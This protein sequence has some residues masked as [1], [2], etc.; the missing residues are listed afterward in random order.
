MAEISEILQQLV[1]Q[2]D[3]STEQSYQF[4]HSVMHGQVSEPVLAS[5]L[6][7]LK[8]KTESRQEILGAVQAM[9]EA[10]VQGKINKDFVFMDTCGTG[11]DGKNSVNISTLCSLTLASLGIKIA[12]HGN[13]SVSS[14]SGSSDL[15]TELGYPIDLPPE[16]AEKQLLDQGY[17]FLFAPLWHPAMKYAVPVRKALGFRTLFNILG[18]LSNPLTPTHQ[19]LGVFSEQLLKDMSFV[20]EQV[21][22]RHSLVCHA[23]DGYDEFSLYA[24]TDYILNRN[25]QSQSGVFEPD[26]LN[27]EIG[28]EA[29]ITCSSREQAIQMARVVLA[30][31]ESDALKAV[32]LNAGA[33]LFLAEKADSIQKGFAIAYEHLKSGKVAQHLQTLINK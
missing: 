15:L 9:K 30:G 31:Q 17:T 12:K 8:I 23:R 5:F 16:Q 25:G 29:E 33:G 3:L 7:A 20:L 11:G 13:R 26:S 6:T 27:I 4:F 21:G 22:I 2:K 18:P 1:E 14:L 10:C 28:S 24:P 19:I 32:A